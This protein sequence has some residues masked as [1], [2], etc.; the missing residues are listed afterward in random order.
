MSLPANLEMD[1]VVMKTCFMKLQQK[2][3][4]KQR[5]SVRVL[6]TEAGSMFRTD[7]T[8]AHTEKMSGENENA[9]KAMMQSWCAKQLIEL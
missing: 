9:Y 7:T 6:V 4:W 8:A 5:D 3:F 1:V 2:H